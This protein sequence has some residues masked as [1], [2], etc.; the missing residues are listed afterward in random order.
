[1]TKAKN[2]LSTRLRRVSRNSAPTPWPPARKEIPPRWLLTR[3]LA[4]FKPWK[5]RFAPSLLISV[6]RHPGRWRAARP[7]CLD[8]EDRGHVRIEAVF[9]ESDKRWYSISISINRPTILV[10]QT[11][12]VSRRAIARDTFSCDPHTQE[13]ESQLHSGMKV[14]RSKLHPKARWVQVVLFL[15]IDGKIQVDT[16][17]RY[18]SGYEIERHRKRCLINVPAT[19]SALNHFRQYPFDIS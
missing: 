19:D 2:R 3:S 4:T 10:R 9:K 6:A 8:A 18:D 16:C 13:P 11:R 5:R 15:V 1:M 14:R 12:E 7:S 17:A